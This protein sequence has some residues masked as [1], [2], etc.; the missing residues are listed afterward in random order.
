MSQGHGDIQR[1]AIAQN[2][3]NNPKT[4]VAC[5]SEFWGALPEV[6]DKQIVFNL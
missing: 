1:D 4:E 5:F 3:T 6:A 2:K